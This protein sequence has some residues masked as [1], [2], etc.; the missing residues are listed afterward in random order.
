V[1][2]HPTRPDPGIQKIEEEL[3]GLL[4]ERGVEIDR[5]YRSEREDWIQI[6]VAAGMGV[7]FL[8]E[9]SALLQAWSL[10]R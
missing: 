6:M 5:S 2:R 9:N 7:C 8:P 10:A 1:Q 3:G 4:G